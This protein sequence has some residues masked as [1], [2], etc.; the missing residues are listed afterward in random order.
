MC[1]LPP[2]LL[3]APLRNLSVGKFF[4]I[5]I[6]RKAKVS[7]ISNGLVLFAMLAEADAALSSIKKALGKSWE[8]VNQCQTK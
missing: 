5:S 4:V 8:N 7:F 6:T 1:H 3:L 2:F